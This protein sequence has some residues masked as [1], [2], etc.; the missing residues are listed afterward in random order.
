MDIYATLKKDHRNVATLMEKVLSTRDAGQ[1]E[2]I[3][4][5][6]SK[7]LTSHAE[8]EEATFYDSL[9]YASETEESIEFAQEDQNE[10][11]E[12]LHKLSSLSADSEK[13][14]ELFGEFKQ[15]VEHH[16]KDEEERIFPHAKHVLSEERANALG[17]EMQKREKEAMGEAA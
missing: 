5:E 14:I 2:E 9:K 3:F 1:R 13:W 10:I 7:A 11:K 12:Y 15:A 16:V 6:I 4:R 8:A 17:K